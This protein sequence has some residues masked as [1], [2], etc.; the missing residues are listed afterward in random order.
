MKE[1]CDARR[2]LTG[3]LVALK[4]DRRLDRPGTN[5]LGDCR[6]IK[7]LAPQVIDDIGGSVVQHAARADRNYMPVAN[8]ESPIL[9]DG[10]SIARRCRRLFGMGTAVAGTRLEP[11]PAQAQ[12]SD[13]QT[14]LPESQY[15]GAVTK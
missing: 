11:T 6:A 5:R 12:R 4:Y 8:D 14:G 3:S 13:T 7:C 2:K 9:D 15:G 10:A 1:N